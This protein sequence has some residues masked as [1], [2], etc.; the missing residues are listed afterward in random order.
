MKLFWPGSLTSLVA[1]S[2]YETGSIMR[3]GRCIE[4]CLRLCRSCL[5]PTQYIYMCLAPRDS[6]AADLGR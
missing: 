5:S 2:S 4:R 6:P 3:Y 1:S